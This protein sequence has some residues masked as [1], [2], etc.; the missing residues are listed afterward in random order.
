MPAPVVKSPS[1]AAGRW[2]RRASTAG[3]EFREGV[4]KTTKNWAGNTGAAKASWIAGVQD[5][6][7]RDAF[8]KGV[9]AAGNEKWKNN[10]LTKGPTRFAEGVRVAQGDYEKGVAPFLEVAARTDL[11]QRGPTGSDQNYVRSTTMSRAFRAAK[12]GRR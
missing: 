8:A 5:A 10:A 11:P 6:A 7:G 4:D 12:T 9:A 1:Q 2:A 3:E